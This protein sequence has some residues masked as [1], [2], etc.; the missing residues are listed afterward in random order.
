MSG[1]DP[2][3]IRGTG[4]GGGADDCS[5]AFDTTLASP[6]PE[7]VAALRVGEVLDIA[8]V[9]QPARGVIA[10]V[11]NGPPVGAITRD[12]LRLRDCIAKGNAYEAEVLRIEG[13]S[14]T[15]AIR[16]Q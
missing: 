7:L 14:V 3:V 1:S 2:S 13:G 15:V 5:I 11:I 10:Q 8:S 12:I 4:I 6:D 9:E 16:R